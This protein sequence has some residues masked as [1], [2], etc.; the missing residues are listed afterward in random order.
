MK[1]RMITGVT[2]SGSFTIGNYIGAINN[3][4]KLQ[5]EYDSYIFIA[6]LHAVTS[7]IEPKEVNRN[8]KE[9]VCL[10]LACGIN[11]KHTKF[12]I[13]SEIPEHG[14]LGYIVSFQC[15][16]GELSRMTQYK[17]KIQKLGKSGIDLGLFIYPTLMAA[18]ILLY[19]AE[20]VPVG[21]DQQQHIEITRDLGERFNKRFGKTFKLP[22]YYTSEVG[23]KI[24]NLKNPEEKMS[25]SAPREDK[26]TIFILDDLEAIKEKVLSAVTDNENK[27]YYDEV[28]KP[29][30]SNLLT[31]LSVITNTSIKDLEIKYKNYNYKDF[32]I[33]VAKKVCEFI[34]PIQKKYNYYFN[35]KEVK[36]ILANG[37]E[38]VSVICKEKIEIIR[39][40]MG[41]YYRNNQ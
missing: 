29:G 31:I 19:D 20:I 18:D 14:E 28:N 23:G 5:K 2:P 12:F 8:I 6:D 21:K 39:N 3:F 24:L 7:Y 38:K 25:K 34:E 11:P 33:E 15:R 41:I 13:Q 37:K 26:G 32:K 22:N 17:S 9:L 10:Y 35:S 4:V 27:V 36:E 40:K 30:I 16:V 1:K